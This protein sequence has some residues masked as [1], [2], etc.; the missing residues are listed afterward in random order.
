MG[1]EKTSSYMEFAE[2]MTSIVDDV[3]RISEKTNKA[4]NMLETLPDPVT[5]SDEAIRLTID[6]TSEI[7]MG[8]LENVLKVL[9]YY[10]MAK[11]AVERKK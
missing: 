1:K 6:N 11:Y 2:V 4:F 8:S 7:L 10:E 5:D 9:E 3:K